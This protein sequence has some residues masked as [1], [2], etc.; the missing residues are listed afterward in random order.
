MPT[1]T[2][3]GIELLTSNAADRVALRGVRIASR[4][5]GMSQRTVLEQTF[6][7]LEDHAIEAVYTFP[8]PENAA[9]CGFE[10]ITADRVLTGCI[11]ENDRAVERYENAISEGHGAFVMEQHRPDVFSVRVGNIKP[12]QAATIR[13]T[14]VAPL[15]FVDR[16]VRVAFPTTVAPRYVTQSGMNDPV[17]VTV[18]ADAVNPPHVPQVPYGLSMEVEIEL[19]RKVLG[20]L[21]P[22]HP[23]HVEE[24][25]AIQRVNF[26]SGPVDMDRD[27]VL[28]IKLAREPAPFV[29]CAAGSASDAFL[30]VGFIPEFDVAELDQPQPSETIFI[31][32]C[33]GSMQGSSIQ[34]A[35]AALQLCLRSLNEGDTFNICRFGSTFEL[36]ASQGV[37]YNQTSLDR[38]LQYVNRGADLGGTELLGPLQ[39]ILAEPPRVGRVRQIILLTDGQVTNEPALIELARKHRNANRIFSF[40][41][42]S[43]CSA[44]LVRGLARATCG[45]AEFITGGERIDDK[46]LRVF[47]RIASPPVTDVHIDWGGAEVQTLAELPPVFD[48]D[49]LTVFGRALGHIPDRVTLRCMTERG[50]RSWTVAV[51][52]PL[53]DA[54]GIR[55]MWARRAI[56]SLEEVNALSRLS[57]DQRKTHK[58]AQAV[59]SLSREFGV[60]STLTTFISIEHR[61]LAERNE[62]APELRRVPVMEPAGGEEEMLG[63]PAGMAMPCAAPMA[64]PSPG[65]KR[66]SRES[67]D[68]DALCSGAPPESTAPKG[69]IGRI[70]SAFGGGAKARSRA[71][72]AAYDEASYAVAD[73]PDAAEYKSPP[74]SSTSDV[75]ALQNADGS[76]RGNAEGFVAEYK[77][78]QIAPA[79][80]RNLAIRALSAR[81]PAGSTTAIYAAVD[82]VM[83]LLVLRLRFSA[84]EQLWRRAYRKG[85]L[86]LSKLTGIGAVEIEK[87]LAELAAKL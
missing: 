73:G 22:S 50:P 36:M 15:E 44:S 6:L 54:G 59:I 38:A 80:A 39:A 25:E 23:L 55:Q 48:G 70:L 67:L 86:Y 45:A 37:V 65:R 8:L 43:A 52:P 42:G 77:P 74:S 53:A 20:I 51:P 56:Q 61:T 46:V 28:Q 32:D 21:S 29:Q 85:V 18:D 57:S 78:G 81:W 33:S 5:A 9:V 11:E 7:N 40:G 13:I 16:Q 47:S 64:M 63:A 69:L 60:L 58:D 3:P 12:R 79:E 10:V 27:V 4:L 17:A 31:L 19:G 62:G 68:I 71:D 41:I 34:Q 72:A 76:F 87:W 49:M 82:T 66:R 75:L 1:Q 84:D 35:V 26:A 14:Y 83:A 24:G 30:A 2:M